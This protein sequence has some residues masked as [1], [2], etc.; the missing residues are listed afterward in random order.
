MGNK[1]FLISGPSGSGKTTIMRRVMDNEIVSFTT[2]EMRP[3]ERDGVD[4]LF[5]SRMRF[6]ELSASGG[7]VESSEYGDN[8]YGITREEL[9]TKL[10]RGAAFAIVDGQGAQ[11]LRHLVHRCIGIFIYSEPQACAEHLAERGETQTFIERRLA[12]YDDEMAN[13]VNYDYVIRNVSKRLDDTAEIVRRIV[14]AE[15]S[16]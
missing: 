4:Y 5:I 15:V 16:A 8:F 10:D 3:G 1:L 9:R 13:R 11:S 12:T 2:R 6:A 7:L 14:A